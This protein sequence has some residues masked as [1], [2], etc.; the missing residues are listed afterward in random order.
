[1]LYNVKPKQVK[2]DINDQ[3]TKYCPNYIQFLAEKVGT[4]L[5]GR[6]MAHSQENKKRNDIKS[7]TLENFA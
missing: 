7:V 6:S 5:K 3:Q 2:I 4:Y 1:M